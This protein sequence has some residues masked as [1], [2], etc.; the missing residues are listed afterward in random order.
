VRNLLLWID[1]TIEEAGMSPFIVGP[2]GSHYGQA[3][4]QTVDAFP[5]DKM[6]KQL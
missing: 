6:V 3:Y 1:L 5:N 2:M 4:L